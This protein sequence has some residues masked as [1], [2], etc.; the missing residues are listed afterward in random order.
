M[1]IDRCICFNVKFAD[2][3][4]IMDDNGFNTLEEVQ[5]VID[6]SKNCKLCRPYLEK[7]LQTGE[8]EFNY[9]IEKE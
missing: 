9:I 5:S 8:T 3:K 7:M 6:V 1:L 4:K 2:V